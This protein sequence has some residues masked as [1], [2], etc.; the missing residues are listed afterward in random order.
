MVSFVTSWSRYKWLK[1]IM[2][3][4]EVAELEELSEP[5]FPY[6]ADS[7]GISAFLKFSVSSCIFQYRGWV[8]V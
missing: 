3:L 4:S 6:H 1:L 7:T 8:H 5:E 2:N